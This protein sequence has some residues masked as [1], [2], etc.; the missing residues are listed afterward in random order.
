M[1]ELKKIEAEWR[2]KMCKGLCFDGVDDYVVVPHSDELNIAEG[3]KITITMWAYLTGWEEGYPTGVVI[4]KRSESKANYNWEFNDKKMLMRVHAGGTKYIAY[5]PH[6]LN[7]WN[8]YAM[9]LD[10]DVLKGY[11]NGELKDTVTGV[12]TS[13]TNTKNLHIGESDIGKYRTKDIIAEI[14]IYNRALSESEIKYLYQNPFDPIDPEHLVLWFNPA[15]IDVANSKWWDQSE[16]G[17]HG[18]IHGA[19]EVKLVEEEVKVK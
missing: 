16:K 11:L 6:T 4:D 14:R 17:N 15:G 19:T 5:V 1:F 12:A 2:A 8:F 18:T 9:V 13:G 10:G 3:N 7:V